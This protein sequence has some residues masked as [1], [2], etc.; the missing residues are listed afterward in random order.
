MLIINKPFDPAKIEILQTTDIRID[1]AKRA[2]FQID[3]EYLGKVNRIDAAI[4]TNALLI[5]K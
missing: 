3:G 1:I 2:H 4:L 5:I